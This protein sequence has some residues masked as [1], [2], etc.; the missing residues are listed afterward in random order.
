MSEVEISCIAIAVLTFLGVAFL[1]GCTVQQK[2]DVKRYSNLETELRIA[3]QFGRSA[4]NLLVIEQEKKVLLE[5]DMDRLRLLNKTNRTT[6]C[7]FTKDMVM[8]YKMGNHAVM[9]MKYLEETYN[10]CIIDKIMFWGTFD[11][12]ELE[13]LKKKKND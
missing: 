10:S 5:K 6:T 8:Q 1:F 3:E 12:D 2:H 4:L 13:K 7:Q 9:E 11:K